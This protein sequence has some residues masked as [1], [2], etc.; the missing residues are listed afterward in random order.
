MKKHVCSLCQLCMC[1]G[2]YV[3]AYQPLK[4]GKKKQDFNYS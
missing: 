4:L 3:T 2:K 1:S